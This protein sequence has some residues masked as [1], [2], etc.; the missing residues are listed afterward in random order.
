VLLPGSWPTWAWL[1][2]K[3]IYKNSLADLGNSNLAQAA[4]DLD[5]AFDGK[6]IRICLN[7]RKDL[8][9]VDYIDGFNFS[10]HGRLVPPGSITS[11]GQISLRR[12]NF[13]RAVEIDLYGTLNETT[14]V[15]VFVERDGFDFRERTGDRL[16]FLPKDAMDAVQRPLYD[17]ELM[18]QSNT[19]RANSKSLATAFGSAWRAQ[20]KAL[21][22]RPYKN[23]R[24]WDKEQAEWPDQ[25][26]TE[27]LSYS[28]LSSM[29]EKRFG[30]SRT[31]RGV[32]GF[33][34]AHLHIYK[35]KHQPGAITFRQRSWLANAAKKSTNW[36]GLSA[37][38]NPQFKTNRTN[39]E[40]REMYE[41]MVEATDPQRSN[42]E[43]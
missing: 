29:F 30:F 5:S 19:D 21:K 1:H 32:E 22:S 35:C 41:N 17:Y 34:L 7:L 16:W 39:R 4:L 28:T 14:D 25:V 37:T 33:L 13:T 9:I 8:H 3:R 36:D 12:P 2:L 20:L 18:Q 15:F 6:E 23:A 10:W 24:Y 40:L 38:F 26:A 42:H 27:S 31:T 43:Q 11:K